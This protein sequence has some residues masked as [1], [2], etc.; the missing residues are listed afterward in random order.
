MF[1]H[2]CG[3]KIEGPGDFCENCGARV[4]I[5]TINDPAPQSYQ[6]QVSSA[7]SQMKQKN[8]GLAAVASFLWAGMG[9]VYNGSLIKGFAFLIG[10][11]IGSMIFAIP[12]IIIWAFG[13]YDAYKTAK[14]MN[15]GEIPYVPVKTGH[16]IIFI[17]GT[18]VIVGIYSMV[19]S[20]IAYEG[21]YY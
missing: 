7:N 14:K 15:N 18:I 6:P 21:M 16:I 1:C 4:S 10:V 20:G 17:I 19:I 11:I 3:A 2:Q 12:G 5:D 13:I 8:P 9:Q